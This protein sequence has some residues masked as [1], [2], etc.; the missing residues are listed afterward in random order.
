MKRS[1]FVVFVLLSFFAFAITGCKKKKKEDEEIKFY[2]VGELYDVGGEKAVIYKV[3]T[4]TGG[5]YALGVSLDETELAW[6]TEHIKTDAIDLEN[7][8]KNQQKIQSLPGWAEK[9][10]AFKWCADKN[11]N[12][13]GGWYFP[14]PVEMN[15][16]LRARIEDKANKTTL[17][18]HEYLIK[19]GGVGFSYAEENGYSPYWTST[20]TSFNTNA[21]SPS[22][23]S[24][25]GVSYD[26]KLTKKVRA[27]K[28]IRIY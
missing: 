14:S 15:E 18:L 28:Y 22:Y 9:Y 16:L 11:K 25:G 23:N 19:M 6:S 5:M 1:I 26:K 10:P 8:A 13:S 7:G 2:S 20:E 17:S 3:V 4:I 27:I 12:G 24:S 21:A